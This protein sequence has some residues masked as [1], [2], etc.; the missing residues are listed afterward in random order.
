MENVTQALF[1][2]FAMFVFLIAL[3]YSIYM[4]RT[5]NVTSKTLMYRD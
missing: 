3:T 1:M 4:I 5:L 2:A